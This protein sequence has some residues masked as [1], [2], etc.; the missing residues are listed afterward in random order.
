MNW[1][2]SLRKVEARP[3]L[4]Q[5]DPRVKLAW[6]ATISVGCLWFSQ[7]WALVALTVAAA[8]PYVSIRMPWRALVAYSSLLVLVLWSTVL[9][10]ALFIYDP[11]GEPLFT[12]VPAFTWGGTPYA[13]LHL[14]PEGAAYG[15]VQS[16]RFIANLL[17]GGSVALTTSPERLLAA[18][19]ALRIP[20]SL[21]YMA[22]AGLRSLPTALDEWAALRQAYRLRSGRLRG[23]K[24]SRLSM[25][26]ELRLVE[27]LLANTLRRAATLA[28]AVRARGFDAAAPRTHYPALEL[29]ARERAAL[30]ALATVWL[31]AIVQAFI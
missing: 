16:L 4:A 17:A 6:L 12:I 24:S 7:P 5:L 30:C 25:R 10:Q 27:P 26:E 1:S 14:W 18:L 28:L 13:G 23:G 20:A 29:K 3:W 19:V 31:I 11:K 8:L 2:L 22:T 21:S 15:A 9:S